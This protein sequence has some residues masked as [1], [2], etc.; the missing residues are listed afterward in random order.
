MTVI[1][2]WWK[3]L[4]RFRKLLD[5]RITKFHSFRKIWLKLANKCNIYKRKKLTVSK[6]EDKRKQF[7]QKWM[8]MT[9]T[10]CQLWTKIAI[11]M[12]PQDFNVKA[13]I[14]SVTQIRK[15]DKIHNNSSQVKNSHQNKRMKPVKE[16]SP[17]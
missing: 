3:G 9:K 7:L 15:L 1:V 13:R 16:T 10:Y 12:S 17:F 14:D 6:V 5:K 4:R 11:W 2:L 8:T